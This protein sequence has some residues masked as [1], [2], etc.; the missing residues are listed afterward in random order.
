MWDLAVREEDY[1]AI[2]AMLGRYRGRPPLSMRLLPP[3]ARSDTAAMTALLTEGRGLESRQLQIAARYAASYLEAFALADSLARLDLQ[4]RER[5]V[6][7]V[8]AQL[9][10]AGLAAAKGDWTAAR[11]GFAAA[12]AME[13]GAGTVVVHRAFAATIP[14]QPVSAADLHAIRESVARWD[15]SASGGGLAGALRPHLRHYLLGLLAS[16]LG[17]GENAERAAAAIEELPPPA[18]GRAVA[19]SLA[20]TVRADLAWMQSRPREALQWAEQADHQI[21]LEL[22]APS[23]AAH[24]REYGLEHARYLRAASLSALG[25]DAEAVAWLRFGLRGSP[26]EYLYHPPVHVRLGE[27]FTRLG[28]PD[29]AAGHYRRFLELW[30]EAD[31]AAVPLRDDVQRRLSGLGKGP[32]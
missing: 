32:A 19:R 18:A 21:P 22:V 24:I 15:P 11:R 14:D 9:L 25:R 6:N 30:S 23:R 5:S 8:G 20:A 12:E 31:A 3:A 13:E 16:R 7:R 29:S 26:Q 17:E 1:Q 4:W 27:V 10:L 2:E 28:Q